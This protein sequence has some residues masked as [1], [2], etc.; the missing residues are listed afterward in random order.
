M[1]FA[2]SLTLSLLGLTLPASAQVLRYNVG[3][4]VYTDTSGNRWEA[5]TVCGGAVGTF[6]NPAIKDTENDPLY[7]DEKWGDYTC[8]VPASGQTEACIS[9]SENYLNSTGR[10]QDVYFE[11]QKVESALDVF[12]LVGKN[13]ALTRCY[14][15]NVTD[16]AATVEIRG[17]GDTSKNASFGNGILNALKIEVKGGSTSNVSVSLQGITDGQQF[18]STD[19]PKIEAKIL[20]QP[21]G[22]AVS[23]TFEGDGKFIK[24][25]NYS[26]YCAAGDNSGPEGGCAGYDLSKLSTGSHTIQAKATVDGKSYSSAVIDFSISSSTSS[27]GISSSLFEW[28]FIDADLPTGS[29]GR[30]GYGQTAQGLYDI[31]KD[32]DLDLF[33]GRAAYTG[34]AL[35]WFEYQGPD[36]W[37]R[38]S[39]G[40]NGDAGVGAAAHDVDGDGWVDLITAK[41]WYR[42]P[43]SPRSSSS[44][45]TYTYDESGLED[46]DIVVADVDGDGKKDVVSGYANSKEDNQNL[47][48]YKIPSDPKGP[49]SSKTV[50]RMYHAAFAP[51]G[52][53]D[54]DGD[55]DLDIARVDGFY[56]NNGGASSWTFV[57]G[58]DFGQDGCKYAWGARA[59]IADLD[60]DGKNDL[61]QSDAE[62]H[63]DTAGSNGVAVFWG[64]GGGNFTK[65]VLPQTDGAT[66]GAFHSLA[67]A[68]FDGD[69]DLDIFSGEMEGA[70][71]EEFVLGEKF[72]RW[73]IWEKTGTRSF[74]E[75]QILDAKLGAHETVVGDVDGD[76]DPDIVSKVW[77]AQ[78]GNAAGGNG[79][80][81]LLRNQRN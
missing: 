66:R 20:G 39:I 23:V 13:T 54:L 46:H 70:D 26:P 11:G 5:D 67:L 71:G 69:G 47:R 68:D 2:L 32:G 14:T 21:K 76:G 43:Q 4:G 30:W 33:S 48:W 50:G 25:E 53:A 61:I 45:P 22:A 63:G 37:V 58:L 64:S 34:G 78:E 3:G 17:V 55:G 81:V 59:W 77:N 62:C 31:D 38:R 80:A 24:T 65:Q 72:A 60:K 16:G 40:T 18:K 6:A 9:R 7:W 73:W 75:R 44:W 74:V 36:T 79:H 15:A 12:A 51:K 28:S 1:R 29:N 19:K 49:W 57:G 35:Y 42:N 10:K 56:R 52:V 8:S 27:G 41:K